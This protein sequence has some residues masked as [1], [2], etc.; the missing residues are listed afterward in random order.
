MAKESRAVA[1][2][3]IQYP[4]VNLNLGP[5]MMALTPRQRAF[6]FAMLETGQDDHTR[7]ARMAGYTGNDNVLYVT[8]HRLAHDEKIQTAIH[9]QASKRLKAG[10]I[11]ATG[12]LLAI[13]KNPVHKDQLK[14]AL[15]IMNRSGLHAITES[16]VTHEHTLDDKAA[17]QRVKDLA[18]SLGIDAKKLLGNYGIVEAEYTEV[19]EEE[20]FDPAAGLEDLL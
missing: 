12:T 9:E 8:A 13:A 5:K 4:A 11:M 15:E 20:E 14:A 10:A 18:L 6:V 2:A 1:I 16:K 3:P 17:I 19:P 7:C